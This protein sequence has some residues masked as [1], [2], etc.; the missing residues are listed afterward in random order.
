MLQ[1][2]A[3]LYCEAFELVS[4]PPPPQAS[5]Q[6]ALSCIAH[7]AAFQSA[8]SHLTAALCCGH[9]PMLSLNAQLALQYILAVNLMHLLMQYSQ[10][11]EE[12]LYLN[13]IIF[14]L[15]F[16]CSCAPMEEL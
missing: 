8:P 14:Y 15:G 16:T 3:S 2:T 9:R 10:I 12:A 13:F 11:N 7:K 6:L 1:P 5:N 4:T